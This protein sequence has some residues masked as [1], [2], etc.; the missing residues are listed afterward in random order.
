[1]SIR[2]IILKSMVCDIEF[3]KDKILG[4]AC[5]PNGL[6]RIKAV[7]RQK[8]LG[9]ECRNLKD[10]KT[11]GIIRTK[12]KDYDKKR[13]RN[14]VK[15]KITQL[16]AEN[17]NEVP[18]TTKSTEPQPKRR[19]TTNTK[20]K[21]TDDEIAILS[22]LKIHKNNFPNEAITSVCKKLSKVWTIKKVR[23]W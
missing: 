9:I 18:F 10:R 15:K 4:V 13:S 23:T 22:V 2:T 5:Y 11:M 12:L 7:Y 19:K 3:F 6:E 17:S 14:E 20:H 21:T 8:V 16:V 1:M